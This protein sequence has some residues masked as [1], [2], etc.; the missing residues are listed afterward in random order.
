MVRENDQI[1]KIFQYIFNG[2]EFLAC[3]HN[4]NLA[5]TLQSVFVSFKMNRHVILAGEEGCGLTKIARLIAQCHNKKF[6]VDNEKE[7]FLHSDLFGG[8][9][10]SGS[11]KKNKNFN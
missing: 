8:Q 10:A 5:E 2:V 11:T 4:N 1:M 3:Y 9:K 6:C 7:S